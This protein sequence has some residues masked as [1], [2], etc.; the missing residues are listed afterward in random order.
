MKS[1]FAPHLDRHVRFGRR[2][3][4]V[5]PRHLKLANYLRRVELP[6]VPASADWVPAAQSV[7]S[8]V[9]LNDQLGD[10]GIA[11]GYH[12]VGVETGNAGNLFTASD[13]QIVAD[14]SAIGGY[15]VGNESTDNGIFLTDALKYWT[16]HGF[17]NGTK[18]TAWISVDTTN[19]AEVQAAL[20]LFENLY[21]GLELPDSYVNP[22]PSGSGFTW[23][24]GA[25]D[26][27]NGHC[28]VGA[29]YDDKGIKVLTWGLTGTLTYAAAAALCVGKVGGE[30][31]VLL[32]PDQL[33]KSASKAPNGVAWNDLIVDFDALGGN[34]PIPAPPP[35]TPPP[36]TPGA[37]PTLAQAVGWVTTG[38]STHP[39]LLRRSDAIVA[40]SKAL[41]DHWPKA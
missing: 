2:K 36:P 34:V 20:W 16:S 41:T 3:P 29:G 22:F 9:Y 26:P 31:Y 4:V 28:I 35:P 40:A 1:V 17:A 13:A 5:V 7:V 21:L 33:A 38:L 39:P 6:P 27:S 30:A 32:T 19:T 11:G 8:N 18:L 10:C 12:I 14:Y 37:G 23:D 25:P 15:V 24:T